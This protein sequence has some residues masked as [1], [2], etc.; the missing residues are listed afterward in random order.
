VLPALG[1]LA[2]F[3][4]AGSLWVVGYMVAPTLFA[5]LERERAGQVAG[6]LFTYVAWVVMVGAVLL[7]AFR[8][9]LAPGAPRWVVVCLSTVLALAALGHFGLRPY[10]ADLKEAHAAGQLADAAY[11]AAFGWAHGISALLY[12]TQSI[13]AAALVAGWNR[14]VVS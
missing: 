9:W 4:M 6:Q 8:Q 7:V 11:R 2:L 10:M 12:L 3:C 13:L 5:M 14:R 1:N